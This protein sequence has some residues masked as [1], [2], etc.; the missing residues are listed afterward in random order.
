MYESC[1]SRASH[2]RV[3]N[4]P[5]R[6]TNVLSESPLESMACSVSWVAV[7]A[8]AAVDEV[9]SS[10]A[11]ASVSSASVKPDRLVSTTNLTELITETA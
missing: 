9:G 8:A 2:V 7:A 3:V 11:V 6:W 5:V 4:P 10:T 1:A